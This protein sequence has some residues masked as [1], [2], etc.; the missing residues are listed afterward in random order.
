MF[1]FFKHILTRDKNPSKLA[2]TSSTVKKQVRLLAEGSRRL[3]TD[4]LN[5]RCIEFVTHMSSTAVYLS[6]NSKFNGSQVIYFH[7]VRRIY[8]EFV[9]LQDIYEQGESYC[10]IRKVQ[11]R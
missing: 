4:P 2:V 5:S 6:E 11:L 1:F 8:C 10:G 9:R 3:Q 7:V